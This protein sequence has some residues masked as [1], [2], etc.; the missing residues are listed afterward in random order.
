MK[1]R[2]EEEE[3]EEEKEKEEEGGPWEPGLGRGA[4]GRSDVMEETMDDELCG[5]ETEWR[6]GGVVV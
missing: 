1:G 4:E 6:S 3:K 2:Q 5:G